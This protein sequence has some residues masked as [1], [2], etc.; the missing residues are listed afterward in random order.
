VNR[1]KRVYFA[2]TPWAKSDEILSDYK[3]QTPNSNGIWV[4]VE[5]TL[6]AFEADY[7]IIQD[8]CTDKELLSKFLPVKRIYINREATAVY[9]KNMYPKSEFNRFSY[10]DGTGYCAARW[11]YG[12]ETPNTGYG[13]LDQ[14]YDQLKQFKFPEK[15]KTICAIVS[16]KKMTEG[17]KLRRKF[18]KR[19][20]K[21]NELDLYGSISFSNCKLSENNKFQTLVRYKYSLGFDNQDSIPD[22]FGTQFTDALLAWSIPIFWCGTDLRRYFPEGSFIQFDARNRGEISRI[23]NLLKD[24]DYLFRIPALEEARNLVLDKYNVWPTIKTIID[25]SI[26]N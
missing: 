25:K 26:M 8:E 2:P 24:D 1:N 4:D 10:W 7:V 15:D 6:N 21:V 17:H 13:G 22:F 9:L 18:V 20:S 5:A 3:F 19:Y 11:R 14:T 12:G 16:D 23:S